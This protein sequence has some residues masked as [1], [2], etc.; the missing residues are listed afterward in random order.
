MTKHSVNLDIKY[1]EPVYLDEITLLIFDKQVI[2]D[3]K[4]GDSV[5]LQNSSYVVS[6]KIKSIEMKS[7]GD[8][9][10][11]EARKAGF[12]NKDFLQDELVRR[13]EI[14]GLSFIL[15]I[16]DLLLFCVYLEDDNKS[17]I[18]TFNSSQFRPVY[19]MN[20]EGLDGKEI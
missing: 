17:D 3:Y 2:T 8:I 10:D 16:D 19:Y 13:F 12:I 18:F 9:S 4:E 1:F 5:L 20:K 15:G 11:D 14:D 6:K 7:F